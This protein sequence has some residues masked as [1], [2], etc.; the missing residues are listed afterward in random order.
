MTYL[1]DGFTPYGMKRQCY[2]TNAC[3]LKSPLPDGQH[4]TWRLR[5]TRGRL[6]RERELYEK[7]SLYEGHASAVING[8]CLTAS[9]EVRFCE[10]AL[11]ESFDE[12][13]GQIAFSITSASM[14]PP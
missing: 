7:A 9:D 14:V 13:Q 4:C 6:S 11:R 5:R 10:T 2:R 12:S 1:S 8:L 3:D